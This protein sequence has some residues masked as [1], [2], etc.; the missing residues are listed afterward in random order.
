MSSQAKPLWEATAAQNL[1][2][3]RPAG[4]YFA[5]F[6][7]NGKRVWKS[8][9]TTVFSVAKQRL[10][11]T[12][13]EHRAKLE[14]MTAVAIGKMT[15]GNAAR[16]YLEKVQ[17]NVSLKPKSK[18]YREMMIDFINRSWP[19]LSGTDVRRVSERDC[20]EWLLRFQKHYAP[21]VVNNAIGTLRSVF[22]EAVRSGARFGD[23]AA[24]L[25]RM[26]VRAKRLELPSRSEFL[27]FVEE[28][29]TAGARQSKDC[30]NLVKFLA[31]SGVRIGEAKFVNWADANFDRR[32]LHVRGDPVTA[33]KNGETRYVPMIPELEQMLK[34][35]RSGRA[36]EPPTAI[37]M[38]VFECQNSMTHAAAK[39]GMKRITH[40]DLRHLFAT[41]CIESGVDVPT[42]SRWLGHKDGGALCMKTYGHL[43]QDHSLA[44]AQRVS[45][46]PAI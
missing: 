32:Q 16:A 18:E 38:R 46:R 29:R 9:E 20:Q 41:I 25:S 2:R 34:E 45:F 10:P 8:L 44:Q 31:Y 33:T 14:S 1:V 23:P 30:A 11:D 36:D 24:N 40:H 37:V 7:I 6:R 27:R 17:A 22:A 35:L 19:S 26:R 13:R 4:T 21:S 42:V 28:I 5:R 43:R 12:M 3:Y 15:V 39:I